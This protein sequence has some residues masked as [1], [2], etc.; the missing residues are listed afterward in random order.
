A[1][2]FGN[3]A[4]MRFQG[5]VAG[6]EEADNRTRVVTLERLSTWRHKKRIVLT[7]YRQEQRL[8]GA[9][10]FLE[11]RIERDVALVV[12]EEVELHVIRTGTS[13]I[14]VVEV[15]T[16][17]RHQR[18]VGRAVRVLPARRLRS[19][20]GAERFAVRLRR[21]LPVGPDR[22]PAFAQTFLIGV[23]VLRDDGCDP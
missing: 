21:V 1:D 22:S 19:E 16:V 12:A 5:E 3:L 10:V 9:E 18:R 6:I 7:P 15:L 8:V 2:A 17:R 14:E 13:Q 11:R 20:H 4:G 23:A